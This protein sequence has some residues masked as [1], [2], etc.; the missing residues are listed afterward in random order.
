MAKLQADGGHLSRQHASV[1]QDFER[2]LRDA[3]RVAL[4]T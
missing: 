1:D 2:E 3:S 4:P